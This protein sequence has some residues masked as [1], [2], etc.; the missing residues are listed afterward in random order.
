MAATGLCVRA[1]RLP[2]EAAM[3][4]HKAP[5]SFIFEEL[6]RTE[7]ALDTTLIHEHHLL[8]LTHLDNIMGA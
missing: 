8:C 2:Q 3:V 4:A 7:D 1:S 6:L 5:E